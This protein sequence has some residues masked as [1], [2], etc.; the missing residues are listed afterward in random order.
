MLRAHQHLLDFAPYVLPDT[1]APA[2][3]RHLHLAQTEST[4]DPSPK[5]LAAA[6]NVL[7]RVGLCSHYLGQGGTSERSYGGVT[8]L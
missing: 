7:L 2:G 8:T 3:K 4:F 1:S 6:Q 5:A